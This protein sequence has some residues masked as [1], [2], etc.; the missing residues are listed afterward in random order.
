[1]GAKGG[2]Y[3]GE[4]GGINPPLRCRGEMKCY[5]SVPTPNMFRQSLAG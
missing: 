2:H 3:E 4:N 5:P 1:M